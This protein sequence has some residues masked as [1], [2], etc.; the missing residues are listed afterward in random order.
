MGERSFL[1]STHLPGAGDPSWDEKLVDAPSEDEHLDE[2]SEEEEEVSPEVELVLVEATLA[3]D[4]HLRTE[5]TRGGGILAARPRGST[6]F[7]KRPRVGNLFRFPRLILLGDARHRLA[8]NKGREV[9]ELRMA[10]LHL[11]TDQPLG[12]SPL[13]EED[14][15]IIYKYNKLCFEGSIHSSPASTKSE[16]NG[17]P[18]GYSSS[19]DTEGASLKPRAPVGPLEDVRPADGFIGHKARAPLSLYSMFS[20]QN[21]KGPQCSC[22]RALR[23]DSARDIPL[24][25]LVHN[26]G[27]EDRLHHFGD[28]GVLSVP[29]SHAEI[30]TRTEDKGGASDPGSRSPSA[31]IER[32]LG[33]IRPPSRC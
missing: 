6:W 1:L 9:R 13:D 10:T 4:L 7:K 19:L 15:D 23:R 5:D 22:C 27:V 25:N 29:R 31:A 24:G 8:I 32:F 20:N 26:Y 11:E 18:Y 2:L 28:V 17:S 30:E 3:P 33:R 14:D 16:Y 21:S 12:T